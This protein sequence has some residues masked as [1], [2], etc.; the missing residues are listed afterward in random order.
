MNKLNNKGWGLGAMIAF[1]GVF[2]LAI[3]IIVIQSNRLGIAGGQV[4]K[5]IPTKTPNVTSTPTPSIKPTSKP[6]A[7]AKPK[8]TYNYAELENL[9]EK[10][11]V[12]YQEKYY[13]KLVKEDSVYVTVKKLLEE[14]YLADLIDTDGNFCTGYVKISN[15]ETIKY[16][17]FIKCGTYQTEGYLDYL[18]LL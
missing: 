14:K 7:T 15:M 1:L 18:D 10:S 16:K 17:A 5:P 9:V 13:P 6:D 3:L 11:S 2:I 4:S 12:K 8:P